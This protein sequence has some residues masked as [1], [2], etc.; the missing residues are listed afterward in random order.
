MTL[1]YVTFTF[2]DGTHNL[3][4]YFKMYFWFKEKMY[5]NFCVNHTSG[6]NPY[7]TKKKYSYAVFTQFSSRTVYV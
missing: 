7:L 4:F 3:Y 6:L 1:V 5:P 2:C